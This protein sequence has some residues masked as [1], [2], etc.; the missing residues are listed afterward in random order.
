MKTIY[1][2]RHGES[3]A[4]AKNQVTG[5]LDSLLTDR[6]RKQARQT[7]LHVLEVASKPDLIVASPKR[8]ARETAEIIAAVLNYPLEKIEY[9]ERLQEANA[10]LYAG[11]VKTDEII[12]QLNRDRLISGNAAGVELNQEI[13]ER[14]QSLMKDIQNREESVILLVGHNVSSRMLRRV[15]AGL[16]PET[17]VPGLQNA[18]VLQLS[19]EVKVFGD[20]DMHGGLL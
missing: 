18:A 16:S 13:F 1:F 14:S 12:E 9:D 8:R 4:N 11:K 5:G 6:G 17:K 7:G 19:P 2:V 3:E 20:G 10:G 15:F